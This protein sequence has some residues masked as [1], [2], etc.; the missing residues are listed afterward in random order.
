MPTKRNTLRTVFSLRNTININQILY[1]IRHIPIIG[2]YISE[3]IYG[4]RIFKILALI[5]SI[6]KEVFIAF[7]GKI[8]LFILNEKIA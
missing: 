4:I 8:F 5:L 2:K 7:T 6:I 3:R 1:G